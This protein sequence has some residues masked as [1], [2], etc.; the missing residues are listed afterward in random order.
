M[1]LPVAVRYIRLALRIKMAETQNSAY[2]SWQLTPQYPALL[3][4]LHCAIRFLPQPLL[5]QSSLKM[6]ASSILRNKRQHG[7]SGPQTYRTGGN[8]VLVARDD[9]STSA[10]SQKARGSWKRST[11]TS[12]VPSW[13]MVPM[14]KKIRERTFRNSSET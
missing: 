9:K 10:R 6:H 11:G 1:L 7:K 3:H 2:L 12:V 13:R 8:G 5:V 4:A 14:V